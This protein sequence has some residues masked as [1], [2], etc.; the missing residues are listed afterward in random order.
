MS[1]SENGID[2]LCGKIR[3]VRQQPNG[4]TLVWTVND[5]VIVAQN[6]PEAVKRIVVGKRRMVVLRD[7]VVLGIF[8]R[9]RIRLLDRIR[10]GEMITQEVIECSFPMYPKSE[11]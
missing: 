8:C 6:Q 7:G 5:E 1:S 11:K 10:L 4:G 2:F 3:G 9:P